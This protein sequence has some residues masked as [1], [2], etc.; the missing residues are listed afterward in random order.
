MEET[1][2]KMFNILLNMI[3]INTICFNFFSPLLKT[4]FPSSFPK[5][6]LH[7]KNYVSIFQILARVLEKTS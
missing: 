3:F 7:F 1:F 5:S 6:A 2:K 4:S